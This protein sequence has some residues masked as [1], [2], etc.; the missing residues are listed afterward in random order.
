[1]SIFDEAQP[2]TGT[3]EA[4]KRERAVSKAVRKLLDAND[5][6]TLI[7]GLRKDFGITPKHPDYE[8]IIAV[9]RNERG[10]LD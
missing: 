1:M 4:K 6:K 2:R 3:S 8:K 9:W 5:E 10:S 7:E